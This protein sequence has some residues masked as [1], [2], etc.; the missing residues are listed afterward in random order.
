MNFTVTP[1]GSG[2]AAP[3]LGRHCSG[4]LVNIGGCRLLIDCGEGTQEQL[5]RYHQRMQAIEAIFIS[6]LHGDHVFGLPGLLSSMHLFG[7]K[8]PLD[9]FSPPGLADAVRLF[10]AASATTLQ[11]ELR[12]HEVDTE[13]EQTV[14]EN[15][16]CRVRT[17][18]L[19]HSVPT[20][21]YVVSESDPQPGLRVGVREQFG[22]AADQI[23]SIKRG[24]DYTDSQGTVHPNAELLAPPRKAKSYAYCC[25]TAYNEAIARA[26]AGADLICVESTFANGMEQLAAELRHC[27]AAQAATIAAEADAKQLMLTHFSARYKSLDELLQ[28]AQT[29]FPNTLLA[30]EGK[31]VAV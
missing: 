7:R 9:V 10:F 28:Q 25:D 21:G 30:E 22:L 13:A 12:M 2:A 24:A 16:K 19:Y 11:Y 29:L 6:H 17:F 20:V 26:A 15:A 14:F 3:A 27:T 23:E 18:P 4:Q 5:R 8:E 31:T 1:L